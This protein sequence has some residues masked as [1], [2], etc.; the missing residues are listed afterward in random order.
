MVDIHGAPRPARL[1]PRVVAAV[2]L[3]AWAGAALAA[4]SAAP[5]RL[6]WK[7]LHFR[8]RK[9]I[10]TAD[11]TVRVELVPSEAALRTLAAAPGHAPVMPAGAHVVRIELDTAGLGRHSRN[12]AWIEPGTGAALQ[13]T[14]QEFGRRA[15]FKT[16]RFTL[17]GV[18]VARYAPAR[19]EEDRPADRW[20]QHA[21]TFVPFPATD[22]QGAVVSDSVALFWILATRPLARPGDSARVLVLSRDQLLQVD[23]SVAA[24]HPVTL[25]FDEVGGGGRRAVNDAVPALQLTLSGSRVGGDV[26]G[27]LEFLGFKGNV[28]IL[29]DAGRRVPVEISGTVPKA[30]FVTVRLQDVTLPR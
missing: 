11:T 24:V 7:E 22:R 19:G 5:E 9:L 29:L 12:T 26:A 25:D 14:S 15:R 17:D 28:R 27:D 6:A 30:G 18:A 20:T 23:I 10:F 8:A 13:T 2:T 3:A 4:D 1:L 16:Q 21:D